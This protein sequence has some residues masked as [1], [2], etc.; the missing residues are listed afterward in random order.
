MYYYNNDDD[1]IRIAGLVEESIVDGPGIR[2]V[3]FTQGCPHGCKGC[4]NPQTHDVN[5]G[6]DESIE[7]IASMIDSDPLLKGVTLSGG[8]PFMQAGKL[9]KLL[10]KI[11]NEKLNVITYT[12]F[13]YEELI[14]KANAENKY[15]ELL[16]ASD[17]L[18]DGEFEL[19]KKEEGLKFRGSSNQRAIDVKQTM[20]TGKVVEYEF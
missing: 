8:E 10:N 18:I 3:V 12:G 13:K 14:E 6:R 2:F 20:E 7:K 16:K 11:K 19:D 5:G 9:V 1:K 4:H 15:L 17:I